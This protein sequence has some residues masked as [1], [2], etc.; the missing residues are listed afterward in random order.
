MIHFR[1]IISIC[2]C[3]TSVLL[4][5]AV[6]KPKRLSPVPVDLKIPNFFD[7]SGRKVHVK[8]EDDAKVLTGFIMNY[9][10]DFGFSRTHPNKMRFE[11]CLN[12]RIAALKSAK[13]VY[14]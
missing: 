5:T 7:V 6:P 11:S 9:G 1:T 14:S 13:S 10:H 12:D 2:V 3:L 8:S 4:S